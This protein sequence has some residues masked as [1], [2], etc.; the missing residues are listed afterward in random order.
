MALEQRDI[1]AKLTRYVHVGNARGFNFARIADDNFRPVAFS[2]NHMIRHLGCKPTIYPKTNTKSVLSISLI[3]LPLRR[4]RP[5][6]Q[7]CNRWAVSDASVAVNVIGTNNGACEFL[8]YIVGFISG[9]ARG[10]GC[11]IASGPYCFDGAQT[12]S[13]VIER[14]IL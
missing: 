11:L 13:D 2:V 9:T 7:T 6:A 3:A 12:F 14:F 5:I 4:Y 8:H 1:R 10:A